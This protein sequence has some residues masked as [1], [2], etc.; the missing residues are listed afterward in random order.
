LTKLLPYTQDS[1]QAKAQ[2]TPFLKSIIFFLG[3]F[4]ALREFSRQNSQV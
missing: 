1:F 3:D 4:A 2:R